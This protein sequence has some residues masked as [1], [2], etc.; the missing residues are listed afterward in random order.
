MRSTGRNV[1]SA[2]CGLILSTVSRRWRS[3]VGT[4]VV[5]VVTG[6]LLCV[7][8]QLAAKELDVFCRRWS[9]KGFDNQQ[10]TSGFVVYAPCCYL[11]VY[12]VSLHRTLIHPEAGFHAESARS[13]LALPYF[14]LLQ[15]HLRDKVGTTTAPPVV[16]DSVQ[17]DQKRLKAEYD[18]RVLGCRQRKR[19]H[20]QNQTVTT[21]EGR[22]FF[23]ATAD[24]V[25]SRIVSEHADVH[26]SCFP[27]D[28]QSGLINSLLFS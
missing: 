22:F 6:F 8:E 17:S 3:A 15:F 23:Q 16:T 27:P 19:S 28:V 24:L 2:R 5:V 13:F 7:S 12:I 21:A 9:V 26:A 1:T 4:V 11:L 10:N 14:K 20:H 18:L 25:F